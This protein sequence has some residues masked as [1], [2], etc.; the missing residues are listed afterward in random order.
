MKKKSSLLVTALLAIAISLTAMASAQ[1]Q[2]Q[3]V[4]EHPPESF[5]LVRHACKKAEVNSSDPSL[6]KDGFKQAAELVERL[7]DVPID[8]IW[9]TI[10]RRTEA[11]VSEL[12]WDRN[13][14]PEEPHMPDRA[15][16]IADKIRQVCS[17]P[18]SEG[19]SYLYVGHTFTLIG[20]F[21]ALGVQQDNT[22]DQAGVWIV[23]FADGKPVAK[24]SES[25]IQCGAGC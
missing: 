17:D 25:A 6:C 10:K 16:V 19:K 2:D 1:A 4:C 21:E 9:V 24:Y 20:A 5:I 14:V 23:T 15:D 18:Q 12:A 13:L 3:P 8:E 7:K 22:T 11:T